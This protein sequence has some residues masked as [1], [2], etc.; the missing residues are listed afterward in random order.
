MQSLLALTAAVE[1]AT[2]LLLLA[3][4][5]VVLAFLFGW[6]PVSPE[7]VLMGRVS[8][9][10]LTA[11]SLASWLA[12]DDG[13]T[14]AQLGVLCGVLTYNLLAAVLL[15]LAGW[16][17]SMSGRSSGPPSRITRRSPS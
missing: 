16:V 2:A 10:G 17:L 6:A 13:G 4:P 11:I 12:R 1:G 3:V 8:G 15:A 9:A 5:A 7:A 14:R